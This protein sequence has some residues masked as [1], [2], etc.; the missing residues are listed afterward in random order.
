ML[1]LISFLSFVSHALAEEQVQNPN[2]PLKEEVGQALSARPAPAPEVHM[3]DPSGSKTGGA[4]DV[5]GATPG[6]P[7][8]DDLEKLGTKEPLAIKL[9]DAIGHNRIAINFIWTLICAYLVFFMQ[10][11]FAMVETGFTRAKNAGHTMAM[12]MMVFVFVVLGYW[13]CGYALQMGGVGAGPLAG[14]TGLMN[15]EFTLHLFGKD[16]GLWGTKGFFLSGG[17]YDASIVTLFLFQVVFMNIAATIPTGAMAERWTF[18]SFMVYSFFMAMFAY[19]LYANWVWGGGWLSQLG[20]N[21]GLGHGVV[22]FAGS[23]VVHMVGGVTALAG[24]M[25]L[26][27]RM[28]KYKSNGTPNAI[29]GHHIPMAIIG[30]LILFLGW[31]GFNSGST[32]AAGDLRIGVI[33]AN[34]MLA[35]VAAS[36]SALCYMW[37]FYGKPDLSLS[38]NGLLGGLVAISAPCAFVSPVGA[39]IIGLV[40]GILCCASVF[41]VE[42]KLKVDDPVGA[43]SVHGTCGAWGLIALGLF[44]DGTYGDGFNGVTGTVRGLFYGGTSQ[45]VAE[46]IGVVVNFGFVFVMMYVFFKVLDRIIPLRVSEEVEFEGLDQNEVSVTAYPDFGIAK[47]RR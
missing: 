42:R 36:F 44:A 40:A 9:A 5:V 47:T 17:A 21:F 32:L 45:F 16:F 30:C 20:K 1:M 24:A 26:G 34:T 11:G 22:D 8:T 37:F 43:V 3:P 27:P 23:S 46:V 14:G 19:P 35:S 25:V 12:T 13:I 18:K 15:R 7:T 28:G 31:F 4:A 29:P 6:A 10:A 2:P 39:V 41:F 38:A 33:A